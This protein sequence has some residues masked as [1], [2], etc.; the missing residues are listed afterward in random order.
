MHQ[1]VSLG[2]WVMVFIPDDPTKS[3][4]FHRYSTSDM[5]EIFTGSQLLEI[6]SKGRVRVDGLIAV[7]SDAGY[8]VDAIYASCKLAEQVAK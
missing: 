2:E 4:E 6:N 7:R 5:A 3:V 8:W 1:R